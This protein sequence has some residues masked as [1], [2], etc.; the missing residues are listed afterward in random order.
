MRLTICLTATSVFVACSAFA[1]PAASPAAAPA[2]TPAAA[3][4]APA[5]FQLDETTWTFTDSK[6]TKVQE[7]I[8]AKGNFIAQSA[9]GKH[10]DHGTSVMKNSKACFTSAMTKEGEVC[11]TTKPVAV[12][13]SLETVS[14]KGEKLTVTRTAYVPLSMPK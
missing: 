12:G 10:L 3:P 5:A 1:Q 8:D 9:E 13:Q 6:G 2:A 4:A 14:D 7:S 11:W